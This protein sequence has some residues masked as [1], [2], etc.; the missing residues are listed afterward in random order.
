[1]ACGDGVAD[2]DPAEP[3]IDAAASITESHE[4]AREDAD[5]ASADLP[6]FLTDDEPGHAALNGAS[7]L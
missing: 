6:A 5:I 1:M 2:S 7:A 4:A 3:A